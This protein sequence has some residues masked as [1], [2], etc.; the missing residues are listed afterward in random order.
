MRLPFA[1]I[2]AVLKRILLTRGCPEPKAEKV[3]Y[4]ITRN[5]LEGTYTHGVNRF[6]R[7]VHNIEEGI[8][9]VHADPVLLSGFGAIEN[10]DGQGG[11]GITNA[12]H[13]MERCIA[14]AKV[15]GIGLVA[16]RNTNHWLRAAT[17]GYQACE[18]GMA[19][20]CFT[21][22]MPNMPT[23]GALDARLGNN[24]LVL[25]FPHKDGPVLVDMAMSQFSYGALE[26]ARLEGRQMP[27]DA[28]YDADGELTRDP[29]AVMQTHRIL[30]T[31]YWKGA[32]LSFL[33]DVFAGCLSLG[34]TVASASRLQGDEHGASQ[35]FMAI[36]YSMIASA[37]Q[38]DAILTD[39]IEYLLASEPDGT[40]GRIAYPGQKAVRVKAE[41]LEKGI[42]V[43]E[44]IWSA[45]EALDAR[46]G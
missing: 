10:H 45:I 13:A 31:G 20:I 6:A 2:Q 34:N 1:E 39:D 40:G 5:S 26:L 28:G 15:H 32:A 8:V 42:P 33:L 16:M 43:D 19:G 12:W 37:E 46:R 24:P 23:W 36:N 7:L 25:A 38:V 22:T 35:V 9:N 29:A 21:N 44:R 14:L 3:S 4:E 18:A 30:P 41:N 11:L 17:Y 27:V